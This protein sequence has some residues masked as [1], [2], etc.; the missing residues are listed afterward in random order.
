MYKKNQNS[1]RLFKTSQK[2][3]LVQYFSIHNIAQHF[4]TLFTQ[5]YKTKH[6]FTKL[7]KAL[8]DLTTFYKEIQNSTQLCQ[9]IQDFCKANTY[10]TLQKQL[11]NTFFAYKHLHIFTKLDT[12]IQKKLYKTS[13]NSTTVYKAIQNFTKLYTTLHKS[14][15]LVHNF[16]NKFNNLAQLYTT[17]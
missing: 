13:E 2:K 14:S 16:A 4:T 15:T 9:T 7:Y 3:K 12:I 10:T 8:Q 11:Y 1:T 17:L 6:N 5:F